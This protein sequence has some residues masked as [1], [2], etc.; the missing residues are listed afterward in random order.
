MKCY[1]VRLS[2]F[3]K[4]QFQ[5]ECVRINYIGLATCLYNTLLTLEFHAWFCKDLIIFHSQ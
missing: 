5:L 1:F 3:K 2:S 4:E